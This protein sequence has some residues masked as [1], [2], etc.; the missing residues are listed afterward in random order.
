MKSLQRNIPQRACN[1]YEPGYMAGGDRLI[2]RAG[3]MADA[4][5]GL[6]ISLNREIKIHDA[7]D[8]KS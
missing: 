5:H 2:P 4:D 1:G 8:R 7:R 3:G 6:N